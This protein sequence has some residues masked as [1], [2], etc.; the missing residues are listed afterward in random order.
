MEKAVLTLA[1]RFIDSEPCFSASLRRHSCH[2]DILFALTNRI[3]I[4]QSQLTSKLVLKVN[5]HVRGI[6]TTFKAI[7]SDVYCKHT[8]GIGRSSK[9]ASRYK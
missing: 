1:I 8:F 2:R 7:G 4:H 3:E 5:V 9:K 6:N